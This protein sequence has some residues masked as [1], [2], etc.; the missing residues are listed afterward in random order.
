MHWY[1]FLKRLVT[2]RGKAPSDT[3]ALQD[4]D[5]D[6]LIVFLRAQDD[7]LQFAS[8]ER[9]IRNGFHLFHW[10]DGSRHHGDRREAGSVSLARRPELANAFIFHG[11]GRVREVAL[12]VLDG[13]ITL[14]VVFYGLVS[15]LNDWSPEVRAAARQTFARCFDKTSIEVLLPAVWVLLI[16][17][18][19]WLRWAGTNDFREAVMERRDLVEA[20][21]NR[22]V[23]EKRSKAGGVFGIVCQSRHVDPL[24]PFLAVHASQP[25]IRAI[26][27]NYL[28][29]AYVRFPLGTWSRQW[30]DKSAGMFRMVPDMGERSVGG[31]DVSS[32]VACALGDRANAVRKEAL[33]AVIRH[34]RDPGFQP[35][36]VRCLKELSGDP[37]PSI[38]FRL[39]YL[40]RMLA[41]E[42]QQGLGTDG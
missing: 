29:A 42:T 16:N 15:R 23:S 10:M 31:Y 39:E 28:S 33:D 32:V 25:H 19:H 7:P 35:L 34:R 40:Q 22:L 12:K 37:K 20:L 3:Q 17:S 38:Q 1:D 41:E 27:V 8:I 11:D 30:V 14:P 13:A 4:A 36:I 2:L 26:A 21:V 24:L 9:E 18:R 5:D 6:R